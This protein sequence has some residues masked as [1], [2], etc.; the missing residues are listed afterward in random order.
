MPEGSEGREET[1][2][3]GGEQESQFANGGVS[4]VIVRTFVSVS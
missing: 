1:R 4:Q 2:G 3:D